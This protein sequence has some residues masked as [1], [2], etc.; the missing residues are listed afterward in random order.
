[1]QSRREV[2]H[3][4]V[5]RLNFKQI[6]EVPEGDWRVSFEPEVTIR[7][8]GRFP[9]PI[10]GEIDR[11]NYAEVLHEEVTFGFRG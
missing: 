1:M 6:A 10:R 7:V 5:L 4:E 8:R 2:S 9:T 11:V 3:Q